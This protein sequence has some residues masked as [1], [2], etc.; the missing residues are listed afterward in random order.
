MRAAALLSDANRSYQSAAREARQLQ[1]CPA[2]RRI[3]PKIGRDGDKAAVQ[4][5]VPVLRAAGF[6]V[7]PVEVVAPEKMPPSTVVRYFRTNDPERVGAEAAAAALTNA[8]PDVA[9][10]FV[11]GFENT[12][13]RPC[14]YQLWLAVGAGKR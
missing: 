12:N 14:H 11:P 7:Q 13:D 3:Y 1:D 8:L 5:L 4:N 10:Q 6:I 2:G 9:A